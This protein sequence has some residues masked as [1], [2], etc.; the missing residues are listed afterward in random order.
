MRDLEELREGVQQQPERHSLHTSDQPRPGPLASH[1]GPLLV[2][3]VP[4][5]TVEGF[6][7][8][9]SGFL[10]RWLGRSL[11]KFALYRQNPHQQPA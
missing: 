9:T 8:R 10:L 3:E 7:S 5:S 1:G 4:M 11:S 2:Y 6:E